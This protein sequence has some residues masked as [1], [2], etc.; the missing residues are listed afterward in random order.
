MMR[1]VLRLGG[2]VLMLASVLGLIGLGVLVLT[3]DTEGIGEQYSVTQALIGARTGVVTSRLGT[4]TGGG[5]SAANQVAGPSID[6]REITSVEI[7]S[8][9]LSADVVPSALVERDGGVTW[10]VPAFKV[11]HAESTAGAG[12]RGNAVLLG[13]V[14]SLHSG[15][16]FADL[17]RAEVGHLVAVFADSDRFE[18]TVV[19][20]THIPRSD[21][22]VLEP[23]DTP[24]VTLITCTGMW[25][26]TIWDYTER[27]VV[28]AELSQ[29]QVDHS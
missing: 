8:I 28:R 17:E 7:P 14:T 16:V 19:S 5:L 12:Q 25:L 11:G 20:K 24:A 13:H 4:N 27:L 1:L 15:N 29:R 23:G 6:G 21:S 2:T 18:Y 3:P 9:G 10:E 22:S 26:P